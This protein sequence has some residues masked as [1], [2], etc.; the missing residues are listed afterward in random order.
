MRIFESGIM[1]SSNDGH[2]PLFNIAEI[3]SLARIAW[4][5]AT[6]LN[7]NKF[8]MEIDKLTKLGVIGDTARAGEYMAMIRDYTTASEAVQA[9]ELAGGKGLKAAKKRL[10]KIAQKIY[11]F[12]DDFY[13][14]S[15][16]YQE[17]HKFMRDDPNMS[18]ADAEKRAAERIR[19]GY[20]TYSGLPRNMR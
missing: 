2:S 12:G 19:G 13:K 11:G 1:L 9:A 10:D 4:G 15:G 5:E 18:R 16:Y 20:P 6:G 8:N 3:P 7:K 14:V 17:V